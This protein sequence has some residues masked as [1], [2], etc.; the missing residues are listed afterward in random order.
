[1]SCMRENPVM[2]SIQRYGFFRELQI[3]F[4]KILIKFSKFDLNY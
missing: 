3:I 4:T 1:M 2:N